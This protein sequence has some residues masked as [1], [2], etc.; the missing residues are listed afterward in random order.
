MLLLEGN[1]FLRYSPFPKLLYL[2]FFFLLADCVG[3]LFGGSSGVS[4]TPFSK[5]P[6]PSHRQ[7]FGLKPLH[8]HLIADIDPPVLPPK[9]FTRVTD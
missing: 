4:L 7:Q 6:H 1:G 2:P 3:S 8:E 5:Y 9:M